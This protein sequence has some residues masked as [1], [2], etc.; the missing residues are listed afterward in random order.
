MKNNNICD[1][2]GDGVIA[3]N[4]VYGWFVSFEN[5]NFCLEDRKHYSGPAVVNDDKIES[6]ISNNARDTTR[7]NDT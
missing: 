6:M 1:V 2:H 3:E 7:D 4:N 5:R